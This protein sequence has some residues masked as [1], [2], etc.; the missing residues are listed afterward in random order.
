MPTV[1]TQGA[2]SAKGYGFGASS[3]PPVYIEDVFSTYLYT[4]NGSTQKIEN[5][6]NLNN[7]EEALYTNPG[8][9]SFK[10]PPNVTSL[11]AVAIGAGMALEQRLRLMVMV[12]AAAL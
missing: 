3:A 9:Y 8:T 2:A 6:V 10:V 1:I 12:V 7:T 11:Q 5:G 4:G